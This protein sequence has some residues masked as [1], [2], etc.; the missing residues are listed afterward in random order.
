MQQRKLVLYIATSLDG[1]IAGEEHQMDWLFSVEGDGDNGFSKFASTV[2]TVLLGRTTYDWI[3]EHE[4]TVDKIYS[5][6]ECFVFTRTKRPANEHIKFIH[7]DAVDFVKELK[8]KSGKNIWIVGGGD[9]LFTFINEQ[10]VDELIITIAPLLLGKGIRL[11]KNSNFQT[12][13]SLII[14]NRYNQFAEL[15]YDVINNHA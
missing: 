15:H 11:F 12:H 2:D 13:L 14:I 6:K 4:K 8:Q 5:D 1:Y 9:L 7:T 10:M 3:L